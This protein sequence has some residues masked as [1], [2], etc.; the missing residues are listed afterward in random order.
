MPAFPAMSQ[1]EVE[2]LFAFLLAREQGSE[3]EYRAS[4]GND[5]DVEGRYVDTTA[6]K[7]FE[8]PNGYPAVKPPWGTLNAINLNTGEIAW[9]VPLGTHSTPGDPMPSFAGTPTRGGPIVTAGGLVFIGGT[10]DQKFR[11]F[12]KDTGEVLWVTKLPAAGFATPST[13]MSNGRQYVVIAAAGG[14]GTQPGDYY[15]AFALPE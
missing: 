9:K 13:Y 5:G 11:A 1:E 6:H 14:R 4:A 2:S 15:V 8:G 7:L 3:N 10:E 12:D